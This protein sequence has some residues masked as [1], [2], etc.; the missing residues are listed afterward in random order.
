MPDGKAAADT[1]RQDS[2]RGTGRQT[3][4]RNETA[5]GMQELLIFDLY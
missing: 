2:N 3:G 1:D 5:T 4:R